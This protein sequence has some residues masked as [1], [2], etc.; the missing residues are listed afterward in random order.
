MKVGSGF[1]IK[2]DSA[3]W[4][5]AQG[6]RWTHWMDGFAERTANGILFGGAGDGAENG[7]SRQECRD[8]HCQGVLWNF[9]ERSEASIVYLLL[10]ACVIEIDNSHGERI[11]EGGGR[12]VEGEMTVDTDSA[13]DNVDGCCGQ[14]RSVTLGRLRG[15]DTRFD[16]M[17]GSKGK[18]IEDRAAKPGAEALRRGLRQADVIV[19]VEGGDAGPVDV[20]LFAKCSEHFRLAWRGGEDYADAGLLLKARAYLIR[21]GGGGLGSHREP[22]CRD[23]NGEPVERG[24]LK[25]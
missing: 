15:V 8:G 19:H 11:V 21:D 18:V 1:R 22:G 5:T 14:F 10:T 3:T 2:E 24:I 13:A 12:I 20:A 23:M 6:R 7:T 9:I 4:V 16:Q 25:D 17:H